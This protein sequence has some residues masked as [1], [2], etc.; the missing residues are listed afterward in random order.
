MTEEEFAIE[1]RALAFAR[2][3]KRK[4]A[5]RL[6]DKDIYLPEE[7]PVSVFMAGSPGAGKTEASVALLEKFGG[8]PIIRIDPDELRSH[9]E[10]YTGTNAWLFQGAVS[11]IVERMLDNAFHQSQ[12]FLLDGTLCR[13]DKAHSNIVR[14]LKYKRTVQILYV[15]Q[16]P[17]QAW[18]FV[19]AREAREGRRIKPEHFIEQYFA[20]RDVVNRL[21]AE[22]GRAIRVDLL[23]KNIDNSDRFYKNGVDNIDH[24]V[25]EKHT[26]DDLQRM[27]GL[28]RSD[29]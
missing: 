20:A 25:P 13:Y 10:E 12:S 2:G 11:F 9:F 28:E 16:E 19:E 27:I 22:F 26:R 3:N 24:H 1:A 7:Q 4:I 29:R 18:A 23:I 21:K 17:K 14:S 5:K 8:T 15:Y 6:T